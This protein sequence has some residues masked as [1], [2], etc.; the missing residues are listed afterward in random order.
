MCSGAISKGPWDAVSITAGK[1][2]ARNREEQQYHGLMEPLVNYAMCLGA[3]LKM[4]PGMLSA[5]L[6]GRL[7]PEREKSRITRDSW[8]HVLITPCV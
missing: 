4:Y 3:I 7:L 1:T 2:A 5:Q 6:L 8:N